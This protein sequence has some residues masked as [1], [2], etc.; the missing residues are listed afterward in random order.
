M[1]LLVVEL[2]LYYSVWHFFK[3]LPLSPDG[4]TLPSY[5]ETQQ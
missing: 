2:K 1:S 4:L 5:L 3:R